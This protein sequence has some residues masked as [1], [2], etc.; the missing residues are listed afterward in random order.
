M[1]FNYKKIDNKE[2]STLV[3]NEPWQEHD[4]GAGI[5]EYTLSVI[6]PLQQLKLGD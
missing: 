6:R 3:Q 4:P 2:V 1:G 5:Q